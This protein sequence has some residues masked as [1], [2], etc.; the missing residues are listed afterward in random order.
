MRNKAKD[1][2]EKANR[3]QRVMEA[4]FD[5][6]AERGIDR[7][8]M[9][10]VAEASGVARPSL[11]RYFSSKTD[12]VIAIGTWKWQEYDNWYRTTLSHEE[13][14]EMTGAEYMRWYL[15]SF[16]D[17]Y[18]NHD[19]ILRFN[20]YFNAFLRNEGADVEQKG[21]YTAMVDGI[22]RAFHVLYE[23]GVKDGTIRSDIGE[24]AM[25]SSSFHIMLAAATRYAVGLVYVPEAAS[26]PEAELVL[27]EH[28]LLREFICKNTGCPARS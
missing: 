8:T 3:M 6:F 26:D 11:Y 9:P 10:E 7:V 12:L 15:D 18:R 23:K 20:Y 5:L 25:F 22:G 24:Q 27:L 2:A 21:P 13:K 4:A 14:E 17:L 19:D 1:E 16:V 28:A